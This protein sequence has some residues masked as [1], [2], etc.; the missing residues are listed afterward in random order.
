MCR[1][2]LWL[3]ESGNGRMHEITKTIQLRELIGTSCSRTVGDRRGCDSISSLTSAKSHAV[4]RV[5]RSK[6]IGIIGEVLVHQP[7]NF[8]LYVS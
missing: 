3:A 1:R 2:W 5:R 4:I 7:V 6:N 8:V